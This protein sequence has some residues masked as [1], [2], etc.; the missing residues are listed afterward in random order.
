M[1]VVKPGMRICTKCK[2]PMMEKTNFYSTNNKE[3]YPDGII[4]ECRK[5]F[6]MHLNIHEPSTIL[7]LLEKIDVP[8]IKVEWDR[9]VDKYGRDGKSTATAIFGRYIGKM[10]LKNF[11]QYRYCD[12]DRFVEEEE[13]KRIQDR[14]QKIAEINRYR[15]AINNGE[16]VDNYDVIEELQKTDK[17]LLDSFIRPEELFDSQELNIQY[18][19][20]TRDDKKYLIEKWGKTYTIPECVALEKLYLEMMESYDIRTASHFDYL[21][22]ICRVSLKID[23]ALEVND[24][25]GF[26]KMT[27]IYD[28]LMK[29]AKFTAAQTKN[30][31]EDSTFS[32][33]ELVALAEEK[34][35]IP[36]TDINER[37]D[38]V[39]YTLQDMNKYLERLVKNEMGLG[40]MIELY[41]QKMQQE[42]EES[43]VVTLNED[44]EDD[45]VILSEKEQQL[46]QDSDFEEF[47]NMIDNDKDF[48]E[49][50]LLQSGDDL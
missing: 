49:K 38:V 41:L 19:S 33:G 7:P 20:L 18:D 12:T 46:L 10:R 11:S 45:I 14:A 36:K 44:D 25:E 48:D 4:P 13:M 34:D 15:E 24:I 37:R 47:N 31:E 22:K 27:K 8:Y 28:M 5:C 2:L 35:F 1:P 23:Q 40:N 17:D 9:L 29:S 42:Q 43:D 16:A 6:T 32:I 26:Q 3:L 50:L 30:D 39:D 21:L